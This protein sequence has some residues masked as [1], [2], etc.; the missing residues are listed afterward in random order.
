ML[1]FVYIIKCADDSFYI[2]LT[3]NLNRRIKQ[4][5]DGIKS[6]LSSKQKPVKLVFFSA[7]PNKYIT[8][9]F[10]KYLKTHSGRNF[11]GKHFI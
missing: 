11:R 9:K 7:F 6:C 4:N 3:S 1:Y 2:G 8:A 10:E 5:S